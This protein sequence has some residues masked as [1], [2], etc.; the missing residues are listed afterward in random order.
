[1]AARAEVSERT[2][3]TA[4]KEYF[5]VGPIRYLQ[6]R[7]LRQINIALQA[8]QPM[9]I[10]SPKYSCDTGNGSLA[11]LRN[12][13]ETCLVSYHRRRYKGSDKNVSHRA[14][15]MAESFAL[16]MPIIPLDLYS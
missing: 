16:L 6:L 4:F 8:A 9:A 15:L 11:V 10:Q 1:M 7:Q 5:G 13:I 2:L 14:M 3:Q 12:A